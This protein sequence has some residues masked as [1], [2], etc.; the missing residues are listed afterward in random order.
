MRFSSTWH[1]AQVPALARPPPTPLP[2]DLWVSDGAHHPWSQSREKDAV[3][4]PDLPRTS[5]AP[6]PCEWQWATSPL[7]WCHGLTRLRACE[8]GLWDYSGYAHPWCLDNALR[9]SDQSLTHTP[10]SSGVACDATG[11]VVT[12]SHDAPDPC[13]IA[14]RVTPGYTPAK[15]LG[16]RRLIPARSG[17]QSPCKA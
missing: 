10:L 17:P 8:E 15:C 12:R 3:L 7:S 1:H 4:L 9:T 5:E 16:F 11:L 2:R 14:S 6:P 13:K